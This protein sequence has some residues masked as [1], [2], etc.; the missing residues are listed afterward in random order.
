MTIEIKSY[1]RKPFFIEGV[2]VT[3]ENMAEVS[4]WCK[5]EILTVDGNE[6]MPPKKYIRVQVQRPIN[7]R[8]SKAFVG[9][10]VLFANTGFKVYTEN[11]FDRNFELVLKDDAPEE[12]MTV[13]EPVDKLE[14]LP[15]GE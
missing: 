9:D 11:A 2:Q 1:V 13:D 4:E 14:Q 10:W 3:A 5:G 6:R 8:Q 7:E 15:I 12:L